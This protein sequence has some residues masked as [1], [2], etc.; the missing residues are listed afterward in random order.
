MSKAKKVGSAR[1][2]IPIKNKKKTRTESKQLLR[3]IVDEI[4]MRGLGDTGHPTEW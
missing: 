2:A 4:N 3:N 1:P